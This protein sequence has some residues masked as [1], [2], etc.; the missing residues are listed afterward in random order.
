MRP[1]PVGRP[2]T[3]LA[4]AFAG[5]AAT[6]A[7]LATGELG[8]GLLPGAPSPV[9]AVGRTL[10]DLQ[11]PGA[12]EVV[13]SLFGTADKLALQV[14]V[15]AVALLVGA[16]IG[17]L[18]R[19][20]PGAAMAVLGGFVVV[21]VVAA[22]R[23]PA[24][25][26]GLAVGAGLGELAVGAFSLDHLL[27][28]AARRA[29]AGPGAASMPDWSRR[30]LLIQGGAIAVGSLVV[31]SMGR[32]LLQRQ[33]AATPGGLPSAAVPATLP[34]GADL[35]VGGLTPIVVPNDAF[36]RID[37]ALL[38]PNLDRDTWRLRIH[39]MVDREVT[40]TYAQLLELPIVE[41]YVTIACVSN[42]VGGDLVGNAKWTGV[43]LRD[44]LDMAGVKPGA[45]QM[46]GRSADGWT[47]GTPTAWVMDP[48]REPMIAIGMNGAPLPPEHGFPAR[49][50]VP[51]LFGYVSAT[52]WVTELELTTLEAFDAYWVPLGWAKE[53]PILTQSRIDVPAGGASVRQ[54]P[55][56]IAGVAWAPDRGI[57]RVEVAID[58]GDWHATTLSVP[59]SNATWVQWEYP[60]TATPGKHVVQVR[61]T[62]RTGVT[63][64]ETPTRPDPDGARGW[65]QVSFTVA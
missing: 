7:A 17:V 55:T 5:I 3:R 52:K 42:R 65:H 58:R 35:A 11:P 13:V 14:L 47:A 20:R 12:K 63:Q 25:S 57:A 56:T 46:V 32:V 61:A 27:G 48:D 31:G 44:V 50:I 49:V 37:T 51:G 33:R 6:A 19:H 43:R 29:A 34:S 18:G 1:G 9:V 26:P 30:S 53:A 22:L 10:I 59:I 2:V 64:T 8:A 4:A 24:T 40:L 39:G 62:D 45:T 38:T 28:L 36:Y 54:G 60:W 23:D 21:G 41:Q 15:V 16:G